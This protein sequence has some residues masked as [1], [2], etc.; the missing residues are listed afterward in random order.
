MVTAQHDG[1][2]AAVEERFA[3]GRAMDDYVALEGGEAELEAW[4]QTIPLEQ[5]S[6]FRAAAA[7][8]IAGLR[9][10]GP[11]AGPGAGHHRLDL[12]HRLIHR[13]GWLGG[14]EA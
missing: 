9:G 5:R 8:R 3:V 10:T 14:H 13:P 4:L 6:A 1:E 7:E 12:K 11:G 2:Q